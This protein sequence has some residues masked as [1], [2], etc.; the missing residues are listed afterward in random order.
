MANEKEQAVL[1][2]LKGSTNPLTGRDVF[3]KMD[4][5]VAPRSADVNKALK[6]L[7]ESHAVS[8]LDGTTPTYRVVAGAGGVSPVG[9]P[10]PGTECDDGGDAASAGPLTNGGRAQQRVPAS[11]G[12]AP[13]D[14][15]IQDAIENYMRNCGTWKTAAEVLG[16]LKDAGV[17]PRDS[18]KSQ[19]NRAL[20]A[21]LKRDKVVVEES[22]IPRFK[23]ATMERTAEDDLKEICDNHA[24]L[25]SPP[26]ISTSPRRSE[27]GVTDRYVATVEVHRV[28]AELESGASRPHNPQN[29]C[30]KT[31]TPE[32][33]PK[34]AVVKACYLVL[35]E[36]TKGK[37]V[38]KALKQA[39]VRATFAAYNRSLF[40]QRLAPYTNPD[41]EDHLEFKGSENERDEKW[42]KKK[43]LDALKKHGDFF[44]YALNTWFVDDSKGIP[45]FNP[46]L[47]LGVHDKGLMHGIQLTE[48]QGDKDQERHKFE[49]VLREC[50]TSSV[51]EKAG[52][53]CEWGRHF[54]VHVD[55]LAVDNKVPNSQM[56][57]IA[58]VILDAE[59]AAA[60]ARAQPSFEGLVSWHKEENKKYRDG[61]ST[62]DVPPDLVEKLKQAQG[63][64]R[65]M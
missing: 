26:H 10:P 7:V 4:R 31:S 65:E 53:D 23:S 11:G 29:S 48:I 59:G 16:A 46:K 60:H 57:V 32:P 22:S 62:R 54:S 43:A 44:V 25:V 42:T 5:T 58:T 18:S 19:V 50:V 37:H 34:A 64:P 6:N 9:V 21:L 61:A 14:Q 33:T 41:E 12:S 13:R 47:V 45:G 8:K 49:T 27:G 1:K 55:K 52:T 38:P 35:Q 28:P 63:H 3:R 51:R 56:Y 30:K 40:L 17:L 15:E 20:Y 24:D 2:V 39:A 36:L